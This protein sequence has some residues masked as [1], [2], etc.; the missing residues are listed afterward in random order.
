[1]KTKLC[2]LFLTLATNIGTTIASSTPVDSIWYDFDSINQTAS[3][4]YRGSSYDSDLDEYTGSVV[5]P[6]TVAYSG[7]TYS[8]TSIGKDAFRACTGL[9]S[10]TIPNSVTSIGWRAFYGCSGLTSVTIPN[11]VR[12]IGVYA[13]YNCTGLTS[14]TI[15]NSVTSIGFRAFDGCTG[16]TSVTIPNS[17]TSIGDEAFYGCTGLTSVTI[18]STT[19]PTL[20]GAS[21]FYGCSHLSSIYVP[22]G[23]LET[24]ITTSG[25]STYAS[26]IKYNQPYTI[27]GEALN[28]TILI[29]EIMCII[30]QIE[31]L[32]N[33]GYHFV[34]WSDGVTDNPRTI[35]L[36][37]D[38]TFT[39]EFAINK[40]GTCGD[41]N[42]LLWEY[43]SKTKTLTINGTGALNSN[44]TYG[45][46]ASGEMEHLVI[47]EGITSIGSG[48]FQNATSLVSIVL[49]STLLSV[50]DSAF[51]GC[52]RLEEISLFATRIPD[53]YV[54]SFANVGNKQYIYLF[55]PKGRERSYQRDTYWGEFDVQVKSAESIT[56]PMS[57]VKVVPTENTAELTWP[58][59]QSAESYDLV[60]TKDGVVFCTLTFNSLGQLTGIA[61]APALR[62]NEPQE[63]VS[64]FRFTVTG[65]NSGTQY[66]YSITAKDA[67]DVAIDTQTGSFTT[68]GG[69]DIEEIINNQSQFTNQK[70]LHDGQIYILRD[71][72]VYDLTGRKL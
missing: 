54:T 39:A 55:V 14:V 17:V 57:D 49:C 50:G 41:D 29:P 26:K 64:G 5:I 38:T 58:A 8:V 61:F 72:K 33:D 23:S 37:Q 56:T 24:Y 7:K 65:L 4:T 40:S 53:I 18:E 12:S 1:M 20:V 35:E 25:W 71:G 27:K 52:R 15:P 47:S 68:L 45:L 48:A 63:Q 46:A 59:V 3:V 11:S 70:I 2:I 34:K 21:S 9:T 6:S 10:V 16:L 69:T 60:I 62:S 19:P 36:T 22:C 51:A 44:Y 43:D 32:P 30:V 42:A 67:S 28:G 66:G 31:A 13:F